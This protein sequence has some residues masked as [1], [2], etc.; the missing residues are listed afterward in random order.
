MQKLNGPFK[1]IIPILV[2]MK[3]SIGYKYNNI[4][5]YVTLDNFLYENNILILKV[6]ATFT[7]SVAISLRIGGCNKFETYFNRLFFYILL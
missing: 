3:K 5:I 4:N 6:N 7:I 2:K 1:D